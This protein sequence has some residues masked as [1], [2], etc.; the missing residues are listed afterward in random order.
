MATT[1]LRIIAPSPQSIMR[2]Y[3]ENIIANHRKRAPA[4]IAVPG[5]VTRARLLRFGGKM[6]VVSD[7]RTR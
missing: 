2:M 1:T 6:L 7:R 4:G 3:N 5:I